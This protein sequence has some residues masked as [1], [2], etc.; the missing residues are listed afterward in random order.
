MDHGRFLNT[1]PRKLFE[2]LEATATLP[3]GSNERFNGYGVMGLPFRSAHVLALRR[4]PASSLGRGY[5]SVWH[6]NPDGDWVFYADV[7]PKEACPR[8]FGA[9]ALETIETTITLAWTGPTHLRITMPAVSFDWE[10][11][12]GATAATRFMN[13]AGR[14]LPEAAWR[15]HAVLETM[16]MVGGSLLGVGR[17]GLHGRTP[18]GQH[19]IANP[20]VLWA[21][22]DSHAQFKGK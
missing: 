14:L 12:A 18:N 22:V 16:G 6:R 9:I 2:E 13:A 7:S 11:E 4:F 5:T 3:A 1:E 19:F 15:S 21:I 20:R 8:Y 10:I 17:V